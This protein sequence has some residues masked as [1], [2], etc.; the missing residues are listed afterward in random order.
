MDFC[1]DRR[2]RG[3]AAAATGDADR[4]CRG[5]SRQSHVAFMSKAWNALNSGF[6]SSRVHCLSHCPSREHFVSKRE[7][8]H[9]LGVYTNVNQWTSKNALPSLRT[10]LLS[11]DSRGIDRCRSLS[12]AAVNA[13]SAVSTAYCVPFFAL[14]GL[15]SV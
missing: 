14:V 15:C 4:A 10:A 11:K 8:N 2:V 9:V 12:A 3:D 5:Q 13:L 7:R 1:S 6:S